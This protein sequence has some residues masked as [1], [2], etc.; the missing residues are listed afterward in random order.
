[1]IQMF[2]G[3]ADGYFLTMTYS[4]DKPTNNDTAQALLF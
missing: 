4:E 2:I 3:W 1:M